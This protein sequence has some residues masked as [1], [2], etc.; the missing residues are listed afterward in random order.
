MK[1]SWLWAAV[2]LRRR[3]RAVVLMTMLAG[4]AGGFALT[5]FLGARRTASAWPRF[6][7][8]TLASDAF[9][10]IPSRPDPE[11]A[12]E[13]AAMPGVID[14]ASFVYAAVTLPAVMEG[15]AFAATDE[16]LLRTVHRGRLIEGRRP[17]P[18]R[19]DEIVVNPVMASAAGVRAGQRIRLV[20]VGDSQFSKEVTVVGVLLTDNDLALNTGFPTALLTPAFYKA[21]LLEVDFGRVNQFVRLEPDE[22]AV[23]AF[24]D[25]LIERYGAEGGVL[26]GD[27]N[28]EA[29]G[30]RNALRLQATTLALLAA[31]AAAAS[32][33]AVGQALARHVGSTAT[34]GHTLHALGMTSGE[35]T[36]GSMAAVVVVAFSGA[37]LAVG[38]AIAASPLVPTGLAR[39][40]ESDKGIK[41]ELVAVGGGGLALAVLV[42]GA[43]YGAARRV[44]RLRGSEPAQSSASRVAAPLSPAAS[45]GLVTAMGRGSTRT[46][47][48]TRS[49]IAAA[50]FGGLGVAA[51]ATFAASLDHL[52]ETPRLYGWNF[53]ASVGVGGDDPLRIDQ[54]IAGLVADPDV[55]QLA[56]HELS[57]LTV[58]GRTVETVVL[59]QQKGSPIRP[60]LA[61]GRPP[62]APDEI[63]L[64]AT[65]IEA[66]AVELGDRVEAVGKDG[67]VPMVVV[68]EGI[69]PVM[70]EGGTTEGA[71]ILPEAASDLRLEESRGRLIMVGVLP[72]LDAVQV[73]G[74]HTDLPTFLPMPPAQIQ[75]LRL[76]SSAPWLLAAFLAAL[77]TAA[78]GHA[79]V[80][81]VRAGRRDLA[82]L[83]A[84]G[85]VRRQVHATVHWQASAMVALGLI[86]GVPLGMAVG[87]WVW[88]LA[89]QSTG[90]LVEP[91]MAVAVLTAVVAA[92]FLLANVIAAVPART[93]GR[94]HPAAVLQAE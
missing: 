22:S 80:M 29:I 53:D 77:G 5:A 21:Y 42:A 32:V 18:S 20:G 46:R 61:A 86:P 1:A 64:G 7:A 25:R 60:T 66:L 70:G 88:R 58:A 31:I 37:V 71:A 69:F 87:R 44:A 38:I 83:K 55:D 85:F 51:A 93:A 56:A 43:G 3:W 19:A 23:A 94:T 24:R 11:L 91:V 16:R 82:V 63:I 28:E 40:V 52:L 62:L 33:V 4:L 10:S 41:V 65:T 26:V 39:Q 74:R 8:E 30:I 2:D 14:A 34:D 17:D 57:F 81:S 35:R 49:A 59:H 9:V 48:P 27:T 50:F 13:L 76:V 92:A 6:R 89:A 47:G 79:L 15:G 73:A 67:P 12:D 90:A 68:G 72:G 84:L 45:V 78:V 75:N 54:A 36:W